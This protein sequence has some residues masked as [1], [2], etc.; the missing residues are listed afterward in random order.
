VTVTDDDGGTSI[1]TF[2]VRVHDV[3]APSTA[4][5]VT[6]SDPDLNSYPH[7]NW[8]GVDDHSLPETL[9]YQTRVDGGLWSAWTSPGTTAATIGPLAEGVHSFEVRARDEAGNVEA[10]PALY[11]WTV[12]L[13]NVTAPEPAGGGGAVS[14]PDGEPCLLG[15][16]CVAGGGGDVG[17]YP[18]MAMYAIGEEIEIGMIIT[19]DDGTEILDALVNA[20]LLS[21]TFGEDGAESYAIE[22]YY[23]MTGDGPEF[24][25]SYPVPYD[26]E[27]G[28]YSLTMLTQ[29][30]LGDEIWSLDLGIYDLWFDFDDGSSIRHRIEITM[31]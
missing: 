6:P 20:S 2:V 19:D 5:T 14:G 13:Y 7:F 18:L 26:S 29:V 25:V 15:D 1:G 16:H 27:A 11:E 30:D 12:G 10:T 21:V 28:S 3:G 9:E 22:A 24:V 4:F 31:P 8:E 17:L 23:V